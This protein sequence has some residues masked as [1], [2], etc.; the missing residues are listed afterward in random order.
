MFNNKR[1]YNLQQQNQPT[2]LAKVNSSYR[3]L[4]KAMK[5]PPREYE[6][7]KKLVEQNQENIINNNDIKKNQILILQKMLR[8]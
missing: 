5:E 8:L 2:I 7:I 4:E 1:Y 6:Q 3:K